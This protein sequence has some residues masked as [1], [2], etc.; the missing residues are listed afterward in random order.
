MYCITEYMAYDYV[1]YFNIVGPCHQKGST[2]DRPLLNIHTTALY[3]IC[4]SLYF[5]SAIELISVCYRPH[6]ILLGQYDTIRLSD[7]TS[8]HSAPVRII[9]IQ[10]LHSP[11]L[12]PRFPAFDPQSEI[13]ASVTAEKSERSPVAQL[14]FE[15]LAEIFIHCLPPGDYLIPSDRHA[16]MTLTAVSQTWRDVAISTPTLW[17]SM[18]FGLTGKK[19]YAMIAEL[20]QMWLGRSGTCP[21][22]IGL[23]VDFRGGLEFR[24][25]E[26][27]A[28]A[29]VIQAIIRRVSQWRRV[30]FYIPCSWSL[31]APTFATRDGD[32]APELEALFLHT[33]NETNPGL[34]TALDIISNRAPKLRMFYIKG[35]HPGTDL[36]PLLS[37][38]VTQVT[39][40]G[41]HS[42]EE[43]LD[44]LRI[45]PKLVHWEVDIEDLFAPGPSPLSVPTL[46][47]S[48]LRKLTVK[49]NSGW[50]GFLDTITLPSLRALAFSGGTRTSSIWP[51]AMFTNFVMRS[52]CPLTHF[53]LV[54]VPIME[55]D[56]IQVLRLTDHTLE[57]LTIE[58]TNLKCVK[59]TLLRE[60]WPSDAADFSAPGYSYLCPNLENI[61][62]LDCISCS[63]GAF[64]DMIESRW[65]D[66][67]PDLASA[68]PDRSTAC[69][70]PTRL[71]VYSR[72]WPLKENDI[73]RLLALKTQGLDLHVDPPTR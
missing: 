1:M 47:H 20:A 71:V 26:E 12:Y 39:F 69:V 44:I 24:P 43:V 34:V 54:R 59:D 37:P 70:R 52:S 41:Y 46:T 17:S 23:Y 18:C 40:N 48:N 56:L 55:Q 67:A 65:R 19:P 38:Q 25:F 30:Q 4:G 73:I 61:T 45:C 3:F 5:R 28:I 32:A 36:L 8:N 42:S 49:I 6:L 31:P 72:N 10:V 62:F 66:S 58:G 53:A 11:N 15:V 16:P 14:P 51:Q 50:W 63:E 27:A 2:N 7:R 9:V 22:S 21:L 60:L 13:D 68:R 29:K 33:T 57:A 64:A 35:E